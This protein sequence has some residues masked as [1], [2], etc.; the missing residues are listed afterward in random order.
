LQVKGIHTIIKNGDIIFLR[1]LSYNING[2]KALGGT[3]I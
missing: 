1:E 2:E 3:Y